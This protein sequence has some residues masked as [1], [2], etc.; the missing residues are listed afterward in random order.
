MARSSGS[1]G[2]GER[3]RVAQSDLREV[4]EAVAAVTNLNKALAPAQSDVYE[5]KRSRNVS[6]EKV[7]KL[8]KQV[9]RSE[10][11]VECFFFPFLCLEC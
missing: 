11:S 3:A 4:V 6:K 1:R 2:R 5:A 7:K 9:N 10:L 8:K